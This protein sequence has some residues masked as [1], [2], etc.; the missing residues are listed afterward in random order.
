MTKRGKVAAPSADPDCQSALEEQSRSGFAITPKRN[1]S[2]NSRSDDWFFK[3]RYLLK[4]ELEVG[5]PTKGTTRATRGW[6]HE[7]G[8][9]QKLS[10]A[11]ALL[12]RMAPTAARFF[13]RAALTRPPAALW[14][15]AF[16]GV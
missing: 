3:R 16:A 5:V 7:A 1:V 14:Q 8:P 15:G 2:C 13:Q 6:G 9:E 11:A 12:Q 4:L 10:H